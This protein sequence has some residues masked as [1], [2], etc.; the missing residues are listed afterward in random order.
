[1]E[2]GGLGLQIQNLKQSEWFIPLN[3]YNC[4]SR[5]NIILYNCTCIN[6]SCRKQLN[7][8][9]TSMNVGYSYHIYQA[10]NASN[11][12]TWGIKRT[13]SDS[14]ASDSWQKDQKKRQYILLRKSKADIQFQFYFP[15]LNEVL[16][17]WS[18]RAQA[19][20]TIS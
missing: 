18:T 6:C 13:N 3:L 14:L 7:I 19:P 8:G 12:K 9:T 10:W 11:L 2:R 1:M 16:M 4:I 5:I 15:L 20:W 17:K